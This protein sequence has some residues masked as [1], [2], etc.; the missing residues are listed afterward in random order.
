MDNSMSNERR[1]RAL[2]LLDRIYDRV[3]YDRSTRLNGMRACD[4]LR[5]LLSGE[6]P[7]RRTVEQQ[8]DHLQTL[9]ANWDSYG[10]VPITPEALAAAR[11]WLARLYVWPRSNGGLQL[12]WDEEGQ[13]VLIAPDGSFES[14]AER[15]GEEPAPVRYDSP[16]REEMERAM[17][18]HYIP[19]GGIVLA[20][21]RAEADH[22]HRVCGKCGAPAGTPCVH[23]GSDEVDHPHEP[24]PRAIKAAAGALVR[25][26]AHLSNP[27]QIAGIVLRAAYAID[28]GRAG[29]APLKEPNKEG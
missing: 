4:E 2:E 16:E 10:A 5:S 29:Q 21:E 8:L 23:W 3:A 14:D 26:T 7:A 19:P 24:S 22:P 18:P 6:E 15:S 17:G 13:D 25:D 20:A 28:F 11:T 1:T 12:G 27:S 9:G